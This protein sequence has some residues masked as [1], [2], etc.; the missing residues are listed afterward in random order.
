M[1]RGLL[2]L[3]LAGIILVPTLGD[4]WYRRHR[5]H[6]HDRHIE[7]AA[8]R[9][10]VDPALVKAVV[11]KESTFNAGARGK[12]GELGL[13]QLQEGAAFDWMSAE[14]ITG[15]ELPHLLDPVTNTLAGTW[16]LSRLLRR[17]QH[18]DDPIPY[19]LADYNAG[20]THVLRWIKEN[21]AETNSTTFITQIGFP[22]TRNYVER[23]MERRLRYQRDFRQARR[24]T[25]G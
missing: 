25:A 17:Y 12:A 23:I 7:A 10:R 20:R 3:L 9:Y 22:G 15:F 2:W 5:D 21:G 11:W 18:T 16:Y 13:M 14:K 24:P 1:R 8:R 6:R 19:A 4:L